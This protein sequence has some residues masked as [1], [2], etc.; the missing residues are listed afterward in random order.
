MVAELRKASGGIERVTRLA[1]RDAWSNTY[2]R[3]NAGP[4]AIEASPE[5]L[6]PGML[7]VEVIE[8]A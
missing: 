8:S 3:G 5:A 1:K 7:Q 4:T 2:I 6:R